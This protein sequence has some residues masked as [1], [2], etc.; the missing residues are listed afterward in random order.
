M[1]LMLIKTKVNMHYEKNILMKK[2]ELKN[3]KHISRDESIEGERTI[4][5]NFRK[6]MKGV[7]LIRM[8]SVNCVIFASHM[9]FSVLGPAL[10][11]ES[12]EN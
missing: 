5:N 8:C 3:K 10:K 7:N 6:A 9:F 11:G 2:R 4:G 1:K 12:H